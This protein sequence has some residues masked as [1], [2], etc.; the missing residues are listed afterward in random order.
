MM[1]SLREWA[2]RWLPHWAWVGLRR[3]WTYLR[4]LTHWAIVLIRVRGDGPREA[5][6]LYLSALAAPITAL[7]AIDSWRYPMLLFDTRVRAGRSDRFFCRRLTDDLWHV[8]TG[9]HGSVSSAMAA[10]LKPGGTFVDAGANI[11][12]FT[13]SAA[14]LVGPSGRVVAIEMM[15]DTAALLRDNLAR[16]GIEWVNVVEGAL[17]DRQDVE[18][19]AKMPAGLHGQA[20]IARGFAA[21]GELIE[22][23]VRTL[24]LDQAL[25]ELSR[26]DVLKF[27]LEGAEVRAFEGGRESLSRTRCVIFEDWGGREQGREAADWLVEAGSPTTAII[28]SRPSPA[29]P[30]GGGRSTRCP[31]AAGDREREERSSTNGG[32]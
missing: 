6:K 18:I 1:Q 21:G 11:G 16:S 5:G 30:P 32:S 15:P 23:R 20:S 9:R 19:V 31:D 29:G 4:R 22:T 26:I 13:V 12:G 2:R 25:G 8:L 7:P 17:W 3:T 27:D 24:T 28:A 14:R 10:R